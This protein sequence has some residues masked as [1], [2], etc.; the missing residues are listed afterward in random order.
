MVR[1]LLAGSVSMFVAASMFLASVDAQ[2]GQSI[3]ART[4]IHRLSS[5]QRATY[6]AFVYVNRIPEKP[7]PDESAVDLAG[8]I[9][10]RLANQEGRILVKLPPGMDRD[11]YEA[12]KTFYRFTG[13]G[14]EK[15]GN[16]A[17]CH[18]P[19][20]FTDF[21]HH[22]VEPGGVAVPT[23]SLRN[24][25]DRQVDISQALRDKIAAAQQKRAG[26]ADE[27]ADPYTGIKITNDDIP[28]MVKF[29]GLLNDVE[30]GA[31]RELILNSTLLDTAPEIE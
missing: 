8:R 29:L 16:C 14:N 31:F 28:G 17:V 9:L 30:D 15:V 10:G 19:I 5:T 22:V 21:Q 1:F 27:I 26:T 18:T 6:D 25:A 23:P 2:E 12:M 24:L 7:R 4:Q 3:E 13:L 20:E 11:A